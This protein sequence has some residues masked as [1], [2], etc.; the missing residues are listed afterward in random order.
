MR[1]LLFFGVLYVVFTN[2]FKLGKGIPH[3]PVY[4][5]TSIVLWNYFSRRRMDP[6]SASSHGRGC[7]GRSGFPAW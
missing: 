5:L 1:P 6:F 7:F 4:L 3:Y 2:V